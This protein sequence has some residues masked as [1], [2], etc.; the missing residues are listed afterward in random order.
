MARGLRNLALY[1]LIWT[2]VGLFFFSQSISQKLASHD[3]TPWWHY[4]TSWLLGVYISAALTPAI[5]W[6]GRRFP[7][8]RRNW[9]R[10]TAQ[11]L[12]FSVCFAIVQVVVESAIIPRLGIFPAVMPT[13]VA[14]LVVMTLIAFH[15][16]MATYWM[17]LGIQYGIGY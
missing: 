9:L 15:Q 12:A 10:R 13:F 17:V 6:L 16:T 4:L 14:T 7:F 11:H 8:E 2:V 3:P 5:L 1:F